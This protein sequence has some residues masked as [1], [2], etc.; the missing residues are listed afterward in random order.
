MDHTLDIGEDSAIEPGPWH[1][2]A[3][4]VTVYFK[5][6]ADELR[7]LVPAPFTVADG[8]CMAYVCEIVSVAEGRDRV[9][10]DAPDR[11]LYKEAAVGVKCAFGAKPG[12][13]FPVMW[14][15][16]EWSLL[17]GLLNGYPKRL[18]DSVHM[19]KLHPLNPGLRQLGPGASLSGFC[20][21]GSRRELSVRVDVERSGAPSDL[22]SFGATYG[23]RNYPATEASQTGV[24]EPVEI[25]KSNSRAAEV[26][27]GKGSVETMLA[28]GRPEILF[29]AVYRSGFT[30]GGSRVLKPDNR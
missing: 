17:R 29:G 22:L 1:Y 2:G 25:L 13:Y 14:V 15:T 9:V 18:A 23:L 26:W 20:M 3:D 4:Y 8:T 27:L 16:T 19:S 21:K 11:T 7:S 6:D 24:S 28:V 10:A 30:I 5:G 12:I